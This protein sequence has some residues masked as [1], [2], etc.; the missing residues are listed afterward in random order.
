MA[1]CIT[2]IYYAQLIILYNVIYNIQILFFTG[3]FNQ[4]SIH[5]FRNMEYKFM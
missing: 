4:I 2:L 3:N 1:K 5:E